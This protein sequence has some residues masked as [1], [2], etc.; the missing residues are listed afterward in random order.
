MFGKKKGF[1]S[2]SRIPLGDSD[3]Q[4]VELFSRFAYDEVIH[5]PKAN[6]PDLTDSMRSM[7]ILA[8]LIGELAVDEF[9]VMLPVA[10]ETGVTPVQVKEIVYQGTAYLGMGRV[11]PFLHV[12]NDYLQDKDVPMPLEPQGTVTPETRL[13]AGEAKQVEYFG[14]RM[15]GFAQS[16]PDDTRHINRWL[17]ANCFGDYYTRGGL[18]GRQREMITFCF[19]IAQGGC[20]PQA[21]SHAKA[22]MRIGN[23]KDFL[24][25]VVSQ[26]LPYIGYPRSLNAISCIRAACKEA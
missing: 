7:A 5:E 15:R 11:L 8:A 21:T 12:V 10:L 19:L 9:E 24:I 18:D 16:G 22:N 4:F 25:A 2:D 1:F 3:P 20:D 6:H 26:V 14:E 23:T 13:K 17:A